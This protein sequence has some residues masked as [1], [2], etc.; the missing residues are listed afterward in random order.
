MHLNEENVLKANP[1]LVNYL[2]RKNVLEEIICFAAGWGI[3][4][5]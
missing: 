5:D 2:Y 1:F 4:E 3:L